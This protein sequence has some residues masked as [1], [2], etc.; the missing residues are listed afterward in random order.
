MNQDLDQLSLNV[1]LEDYVSLDKFIDCKSTQ[2]FLNFLRST[3]SDN[4]ISNLYF[5][6]GAEGVG[7]SYIMQSLNREFLDLGK[8]TFHLSLADKRISSHEI[9]QNLDSM[10]IV[11]IENIDHL[12]ADEAWESEVFKLL[13]EA[14]SVNTKIYI[15]SQVVSKD[16]RISLKDLMSRLSYC[17][18]IEVPEISQEEKIEAL[19]Q[20]SSRKGINL[21]TKTIQ[22]IINNTSRSLSD[23]LQLINDIDSFSLK[24]KKKVSVSL[25]KEFLNTKN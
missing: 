25:V 2:D 11:I 4:S 21:D 17:T 5:I 20:S 7:K 8:K 10:D 18:A 23:L 15:S 16:L 9:F 14:L 19:K 3:I 1:A 12:P 13:N 24:K 22:Y 6:W